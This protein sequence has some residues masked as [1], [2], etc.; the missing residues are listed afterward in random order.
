MIAFFDNIA[1]R[2][3]MTVFVDTD[4]P[5]IRLIIEIRFYL[6]RHIQHFQ[7]VY[8]NTPQRFL[9]GYAGVKAVTVQILC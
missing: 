9:I 5:A 6:I 7:L 3:K 1:A 4:I 2:V 8:I